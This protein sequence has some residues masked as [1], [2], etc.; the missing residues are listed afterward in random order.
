[1]FFQTVHFS[2]LKTLLI[3]LFNILLFRNVINNDI[4]ILGQIIK[5]YMHIFFVLYIKVRSS[6]EKKHDFFYRKIYLM[7]RKTCEKYFWVYSV[8]T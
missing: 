6:K 7:L 1:M 3:K 4:K 8:Y 5:I 2:K